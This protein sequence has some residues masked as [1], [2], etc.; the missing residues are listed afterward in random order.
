MKKSQKQSEAD[1]YCTNAMLQLLDAFIECGQLRRKT[2]NK[3]AAK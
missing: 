2:N 3:Q 1:P